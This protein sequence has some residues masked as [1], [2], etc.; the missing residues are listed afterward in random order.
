LCGIKK[1]VILT[2]DK[3][4]RRNWNG[5]KKVLLLPFS[6]KY[7]ASSYRLSLCQFFVPRYTYTFWVIA[8]SRF[9]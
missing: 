8:F 4:A 7:S 9:G 5:D 3:L 6:E 1:G 2:K